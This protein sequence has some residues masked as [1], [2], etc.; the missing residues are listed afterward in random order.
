MSRRDDPERSAPRSA[1][2][3][4]LEKRGR[5][6][7]GE[8][9]FEN[10]PRLVVDRDRRAAVGDLVLLRVSNRGGGRGRAHAQVERRVGRPDV[11]RDVIEALM[12]HRGL[13]RRFDPAVERAARDPE[14]VA[15]DGRRDLRDLTTFT[16]DPTSAR[17]FDDAISAEQRGPDGT[18][19][20]IWVHIADVSAYV[21]PGSPI[22][23]EA[24]R[25]AT[26][27]YVPGKVEP[28]LPE[29]LSN[30]ACSLRPG[31]DRLAVT[32]EI[33]LRGTEVERTAF[34]RST[35]RSDERFD[36]DRVDRIF[37]GA[38]AA[39]EPWATP[40]AAARAA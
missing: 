20:R 13:R 15:F 10:G 14:P 19:W 3:A 6:V 2:V 9:F 30:G 11:A 27:V 21:R 16:I 25:R 22:D 40:L 38:E 32:V 36:Y 33:D 4:V 29:T 34:Y 5:F 35:I 17:D 23:R 8:P 18:G 31:E 12:L 37:A 7:I 26:S 24:Y 28:M 1:V 39:L